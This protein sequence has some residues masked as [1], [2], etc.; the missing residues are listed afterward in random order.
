MQRRLACAL[1][2]WAFAWSAAGIS[3][4]QEV[5]FSQEANQ[6]E[7][8]ID[9]KPVAAYVWSD[10]K[11][12]RPYWAH[13][14]APNGVQV[15]RNHPPVAGKDATDHDT[16]HPGI[17][18]AFGDL[19]G[20]DFWRNRAPVVHDGFAKKP[21]GG[22]KQGAFTVRNRYLSRPGGEMLCREECRLEFRVRPAGYLL[23]WDSHF[24]ADKPVTFGDQ[25]E[26]GLG[27]RVATPMT[28]K[29]GGT[30]RSSQGRVNEPAVWGTTAAWCD[31]SG[32]VEG[33]RVG[34][35]L[36]PHPDN[37]RPSWFHARDY[38]VLVANPFG[39]QAFGHG[40]KSQVTV[41]PGKPFRLRFGVLIHTDEGPERLRNAYADYRRLETPQ[42]GVVQ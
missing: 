1:F 8:C 24:T 36:M 29:A 14:L 32:T 6:L 31:Y 16:F 17:W 42:P 12:T 15:T 28:V 11:I 40:E 18:M 23:V 39:R 7:V 5:S 10:P 27:F 19:S 37:F 2:G 21:A 22:T 3:V 34:L 4:G 41:E 33:K 9:G 38:G 25:E 35:T 30:I 13:V 26:M 20:A